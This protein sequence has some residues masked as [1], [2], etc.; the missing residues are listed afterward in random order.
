MRE[1][2]LS[3]WQ[4][5]VEQDIVS[6]LD[7]SFREAGRLAEAFRHALLSGGKRIRPILVH[8]VASAL[9]E[10]RDVSQAALAVEFFHTASLVADDLPCMDDALE[11]RGKPALH[12]LFGEAISLLTTYLFIAAGYDC[13]SKNGLAL[14]GSERAVLLAIE[15]V[16][17]NT[18]IAG[19]TGGQYL[20]LFLST[21]DRAAIDELIAKKTSSLFEMSFVLGWLYGGGEEERLPL[22]K[23][24]AAHFGLAF[25]IADDL[26]DQEE[27]R[28]K[29]G[30][31]AN[32]LG[33]EA[34]IERL[35]KERSL[36]LESLDKLGLTNLK[37]LLF[38]L[39]LA[40]G[41]IS[42]CSAPAE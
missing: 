20:D 3:G 7:T 27:D 32:F 35:E 10:K 29:V 17:L 26:C 12:R 19:A 36:W 22:V 8:M 4:K 42:F 34:A 6:Y 40:D 15:N 9:E 1:D 41:S 21:P 33:R 38:L 25:Q 5:R 24:C 31:L 2:C 39:E 16:S 18:G 28:E 30:N 23:E 37:E 11:R 13:L 14:P